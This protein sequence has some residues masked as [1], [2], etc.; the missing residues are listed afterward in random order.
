MTDK[1]EEMAGRFMAA[2]DAGYYDDTWDVFL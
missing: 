2:V 1:L